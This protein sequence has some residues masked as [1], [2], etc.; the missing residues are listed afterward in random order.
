MEEI[1]VG[2]T[3]FSLLLA[4]KAEVE[5]VGYVFNP[6]PGRNKVVEEYWCKGL[7][8]GERHLDFYDEHNKGKTFSF[9]NNNRATHILPEDW[10]YVITELKK[11]SK[12]DIKITLN[13]EYDAIVTKNKVVV[14]CQEFEFSR[15]EELYKAVQ[16]QQSK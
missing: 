4:L 14:G 7:G 6:G 3:D 8:G 16:T 11:N 12:P 1:I 5:K 15:I 13:S 9:S 2:A 10:N